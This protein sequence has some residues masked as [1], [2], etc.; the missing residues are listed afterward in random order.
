[1]RTFG[2]YARRSVENCDL[3]VED[4]QLKEDGVA[5]D[6][7]KRQNPNPPNGK[8]IVPTALCRPI[9]MSQQPQS[10]KRVRSNTSNE[11]TPQTAPG[12]RGRPP[13]HPNNSHNNA[14]IGLYAPTGYNGT[15]GAIPGGR[16]DIGYG[17]Y[18][19]TNQPNGYLQAPFA[20]ESYDPHGQS[21]AYAAPYGQPGEHI[22]NPGGLY[23]QNNANN[24]RN[25]VYTSQV[26]LRQAV[27]VDT[28]AY[29][30]SAALGN[31][32]S[33]TYAAVQGQ[34]AA[35]PPRQNL[36][37]QYGEPQYT[38]SYSLT[39]NPAYHSQATSF[40][41]A[42]VDHQYSPSISRTNTIGNDLT[43]ESHPDEFDEEHG[44]DEDA[45]G[46]TADEAEISEVSC[47][48]LG[49]VRTYGLGC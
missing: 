47:V 16:Q 18:T 43:P 28:E 2:P 10:A 49:A 27:S 41:E 12:L 21:N 42:T 46:E 31:G 22:T 44:S 7:L 23:A 19:A 20:A 26:A 24:T 15:Y 6:N 4:S 48:P 45:Q 5:D 32:Q 37:Q 38:S 39:H 1:M 35:T 29:S 36:H 3:V 34:A 8:H 33:P 30:P 25:G 14:S 9:A 11:V 17:S 40:S 13:P